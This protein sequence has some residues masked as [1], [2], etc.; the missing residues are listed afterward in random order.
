MI[1]TDLES[2]S[3]PSET[4]SSKVKVVASLGA[5]KEGATVSAPERVTE[6]PPVCVHA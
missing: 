4:V 6:D 3:V 1:V 5:V 2:L